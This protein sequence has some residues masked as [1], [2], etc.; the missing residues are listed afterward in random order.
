[1]E[2]KILSRQLRQLLYYD[3]TA[4]RKAQIY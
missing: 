2:T 4:I 3:V 1:M